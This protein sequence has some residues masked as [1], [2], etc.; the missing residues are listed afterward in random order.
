MVGTSIW[1]QLFFGLCLG[2]STLFSAEVSAVPISIINHDFED[3]ALPEYPATGS[4]IP[5][6]ADW[7]TTGSNGTWNPPDL[8]TTFFDLGAVDGQAA[9]V[10]S[11]VI[12]QWVVDGS[13]NKVLLEAD[14][15]YKL[16]VD[17]GWRNDLAL[18]G[19]KIAFGA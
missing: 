12:G 18:P 19:Y 11:G 17:V 10:N 3:P 5:S 15:T 4:V 13:S 6:I 14:T 7:A 16:E 1:R 8:V 9:F 2:I